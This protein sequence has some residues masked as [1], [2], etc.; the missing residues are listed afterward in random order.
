MQNEKWN[1]IVIFIKFHFI[2][3]PIYHWIVP[4][5][6]LS[7]IKDFIS[8]PSRMWM[9]V[10]VSVHNPKA[11]AIELRQSVCIFVLR[12][13]RPIQADKWHDEHK[14]LPPHIVFLPYFIQT[15]MIAAV[16]YE[17]WITHTDF[18]R[19]RK[20]NVNSFHCSARLGK[21]QKKPEPF[22]GTVLFI[23]FGKISSLRYGSF[24]R[25]HAIGYAITC[26]SIYCARC[27]SITLDVWPECM[28]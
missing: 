20:K 1:P 5:S 9:C 13:Y 3:G 24:G 16:I 6:M 8:Q 10:A 22:L 27:H 14:L 26:I 4:L 15:A 7:K 17:W 19:E 28:Y 12:M 23:K 25:V 21:Q 18:Q 2:Y 11:I